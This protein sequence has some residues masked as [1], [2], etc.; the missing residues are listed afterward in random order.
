MEKVEISFGFPSPSIVT[1]ARGTWAE[2]LIERKSSLKTEGEGG[3]IERMPML[4]S[5]GGSKNRRKEPCTLGARIAAL[6]K[7]EGGWKESK[8]YRAVGKRGRGGLS[9]LLPGQYCGKKISERR[10]KGRGLCKKKSK[11]G[12]WTSGSPPSRVK[13]KTERRKIF[14]L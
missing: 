8:A 12:G 9:G 3:Y 1:R 14:N 5:F 7:R 4:F 2:T 13:D 6:E 11:E 10:G